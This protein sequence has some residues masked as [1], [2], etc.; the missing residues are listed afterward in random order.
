MERQA[1]IRR[2]EATEFAVLSDLRAMEDPVRATLMA[3]WREVFRRSRA[4]WGIGNSRAETDL[5]GARAHVLLEN[6]FWLPAWLGRYD[7]DQF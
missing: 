5:Y 2:C 4:L 7:I 1:R 3:G 6:T